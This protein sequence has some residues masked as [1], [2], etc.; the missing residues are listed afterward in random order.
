M[1]SDLTVRG[2]RCSGA[3]EIYL[4]DLLTLHMSYALSIGHNVPR[5]NFGEWSSPHYE[6]FHKALRPHAQTRRGN[7]SQ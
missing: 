3:S 1:R 4:I 2:P 6:I 7:C 5:L